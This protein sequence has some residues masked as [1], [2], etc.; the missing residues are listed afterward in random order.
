MIQKGKTVYFVPLFGILTQI[1]LLNMNI[2]K[3]D[4]FNFI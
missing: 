1:K 3:P 4:T 2:H